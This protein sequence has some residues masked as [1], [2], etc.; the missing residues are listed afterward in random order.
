MTLQRKY[1]IKDV[2]FLITSDTIINSAIAN[3]AFLGTK[4]ST[5]TLP[6]F[7][8]IETQIE[9]A[10]QTYL[11]VDNA[12]QL[13]EKSQAVFAIVKPANT[14]LAEVKVQ[15]E[16]DFKDTPEQKS[17]ILNTLGYT[18]YYAKARRGDQE[19]LID[20]LYQF[21]TNLTPQLASKIVDKGTAQAS[22]DGITA[23]A[24]EL[25]DANVEQEIAKGTRK[26]ITE[27]AIAEFNAIYDQIIAIARIASK[28]YKDKKSLADQF[29]F[30]KVAKALNNTKK[31]TPNA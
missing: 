15:I 1:P 2:E 27:E 5:W 28:F 16:Q 21:K 11:G 19:A 9:N 17:E 31:A 14:L 10:I 23:Y 22:L 24:D 26:E 30:T 4:R 18:T 7:Q 13:R 12:K 8:S 29:S 25:K 6:F 3:Q 20:L